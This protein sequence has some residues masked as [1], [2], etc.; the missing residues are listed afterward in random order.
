MVAGDFDARPIGEVPTEVWDRWRHDLDFV[1]PN[2]VLWLRCVVLMP[3]LP[4]RSR[5]LT[6]NA[7]AV[8]ALNT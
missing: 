2:G 7:W 3:M 6:R 5:L 8:S 1:P 4:A